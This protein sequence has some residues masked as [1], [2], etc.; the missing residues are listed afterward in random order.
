MYTQISECTVIKTIFFTH[1]S[2]LLLNAVK[3]VEE[4]LL[5][6]CGNAF[7]QEAKQFEVI[8]SS[9]SSKLRYFCVISKIFGSWPLTVS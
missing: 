8:P 6:K 7:D 2:A 1:I 4:R 3:P 9:F 5:A